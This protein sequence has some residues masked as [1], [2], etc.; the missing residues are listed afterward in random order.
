MTSMT[1]HQNKRP[2]YFRDDLF[3][4]AF[5]KKLQAYPASDERTMIIIEYVFI[6]NG[7]FERV[8][9]EL[10]ARFDDE[11]FDEMLDST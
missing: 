6:T 8:G 11:E 7:C 5:L 9:N 1:K 10:V 2:D 4:P 3:D